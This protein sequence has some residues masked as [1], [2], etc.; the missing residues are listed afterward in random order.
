MSM[1]TT[2][3]RPPLA[4]YPSAVPLDELTRLLT[5]DVGASI[6]VIGALVVLFGKR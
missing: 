6:C 5:Q 4:H 3:F 2:R 1:E